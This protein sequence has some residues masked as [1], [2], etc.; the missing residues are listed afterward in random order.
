MVIRTHQDEL[1]EF[2]VP[3]FAHAR[4]RRMRLIIEKTLSHINRCR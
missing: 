1:A 2:A 3:T 4:R